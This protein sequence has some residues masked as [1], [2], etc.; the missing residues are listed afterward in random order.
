MALFAVASHLAP[1]DIR[2]AIGT[3]RSDISEY[4]LDVALAALHPDVHPAQ[5]VPGF[6]VIEVGRWTNRAP[7][8]GSMTVLA[9]NAEVP[10]RIAC[11]SLL[12]FAGRGRTSASAHRKHD[13]RKQPDEI[14]RPYTP[15]PERSFGFRAIHSRGRFVPYR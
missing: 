3:V 6:V 10:V 4:E 15:R 9:C 8:R 14:S 1:V 5:R 12:L 11:S 2:V 13:Q 7:T